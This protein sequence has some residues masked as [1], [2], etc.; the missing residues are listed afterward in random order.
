[1][2]I[3]LGAPP[4]LLLPSPPRVLEVEVELEVR[5]VTEAAEDT[6]VIFL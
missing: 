1:M 6:I 4:E 2:G 5:L 3:G